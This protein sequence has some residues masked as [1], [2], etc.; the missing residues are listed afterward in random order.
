MLS[1]YGSEHGLRVARKHIGWYT[2]GVARSAAFRQRV[3]AMT[4]VDAV[5]ASIR[6]LFALA[7]DET[8]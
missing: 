6:D 1:H 2:K 7:A 8:A 4:G 5:R 3:F